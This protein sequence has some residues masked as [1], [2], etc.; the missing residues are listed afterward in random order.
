MKI[1]DRITEPFV[2]TILDT[3]F[4]FCL[5]LAISVWHI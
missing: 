5:L 4:P 2:I 1:L 3:P